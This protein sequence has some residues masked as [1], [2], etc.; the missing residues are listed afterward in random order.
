MVL[1]TA[2]LIITAWWLG[3]GGNH[4]PVSRRNVNT[5]SNRKVIQVPLVVIVSIFIAKPISSLYHE[6]KE[7]KEE[8]E[9]E[10]ERKG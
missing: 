3:T 8:K 5:I 1:N 7:E 6:E 10:E 2:Q 4:E 9:E